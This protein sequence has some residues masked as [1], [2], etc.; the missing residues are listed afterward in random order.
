VIHI[1]VEREN[2]RN[3]CIDKAKMKRR[4]KRIKEEKKKEEI[5][6]EMAKMMLNE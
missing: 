1:K 4:K 2:L 6:I 5:H 3:E